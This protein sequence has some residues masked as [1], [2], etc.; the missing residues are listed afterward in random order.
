M[1]LAPITN[2]VGQGRDRALSSNKQTTG[3]GGARPDDRGDLRRPALGGATLN[4][5]SLWVSG[6][7]K[8]IRVMLGTG[9][10]CERDRLPAAL[11]H[12]GCFAT[13]T[14]SMRRLGSAALDLCYAAAGRLDGYYDWGTPNPTSA[15]APTRNSWPGSSTS[16]PGRRDSAPTRR[17]SKSGVRARWGRSGAG[18]LRPTSTA[19]WA[20]DP[21]RWEA[22]NVL[23]GSR[24]GRRVSG[25]LGGWDRPALS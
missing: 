4:G 22:R 16:T 14:Q 15:A 12:F 23:L 1:R 9:F 13:S 24:V 21:G 5:H 2:P 11:E 25:H 18:A 10:P 17:G 6:T 8:P 3:R 19:R 7:A 20:G